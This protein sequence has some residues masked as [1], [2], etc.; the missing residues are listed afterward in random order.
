MQQ[1]LDKAIHVL[2]YWVEN[3]TSYYNYN[4]PSDRSK[5]YTATGVEFGIVTASRPNTPVVF[6]P[7]IV[8]P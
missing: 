7:K 6:L 2:K 3:G 1:E 5:V 4:T 8:K